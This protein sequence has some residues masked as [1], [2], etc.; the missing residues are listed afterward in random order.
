MVVAEGAGKDCAEQSAEGEYG[1][2]HGEL[3]DV[4]GN[5]LREV[6][7]EAGGSDAPL[8]ACDY[9]LR[10][11]KLSLRFLCSV[12]GLPREER[13]THKVVAELEGTE[14]ADEEDVAEI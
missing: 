10:S 5:A 14:C 7:V 9:I 2:D 13:R 8:L 1:G 11:I 4:H 3:A 12:F 6:C